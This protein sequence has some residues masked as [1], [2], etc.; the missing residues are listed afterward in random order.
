MG[1][2]N[3]EYDAIAVSQQL[4]VRPEVLKR[5]VISFSKTLQ[6]K[7]AGLQEAF[8]NGDVLKMRALLHE[9]RGTSGNLRLE[10]VYSTARVMH[11]AVKSGEDKNNV[12]QYFEGLKSSAAQ[13]FEFAKREE[14]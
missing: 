13:L 11:E 1:T 9:I 12:A 5:I 8:N 3:F 6:E 4:H 7:I 14:T 10:K 2:E